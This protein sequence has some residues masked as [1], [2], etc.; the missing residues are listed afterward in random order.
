V[1]ASAPLRVIFIFWSRWMSV[2]ATVLDLRLTA[3]RIHIAEPS[4]LLAAARL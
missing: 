1:K 3:M 4:Y 2:G